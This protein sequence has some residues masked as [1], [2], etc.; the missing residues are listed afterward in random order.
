MQYH[1]MAHDG[2]NISSES[3]LRL[4]LEKAISE[5][6]GNGTNEI[7]LLAHDLKILQ[8]NILEGVIGEKQVKNFVKQRTMKLESVTVYLETEKIKHS[9]FSR[10]I[11]F[12]PFISL[13]LLKEVLLDTRATDIIYVPWSKEEFD[14]YVQDTPAST[15]LQ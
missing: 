6:K 1:T 13:K 8:G 2:K 14:L 4:G 12:A 7:L 3:T 5:A 9:L 11:L 10:G 15:L